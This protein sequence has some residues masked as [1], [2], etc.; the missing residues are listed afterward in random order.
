MNKESIASIITDKLTIKPDQAIELLKPG[1]YVAVICN[2]LEYPEITCRFEDVGFIIH[3]MIGYI[4]GV[5]CGMGTVMLAQKPHLKPMINNVEKY[6][7]GAMNID[8]CRVET[9]GKDKEKHLAEWNRNQSMS[10]QQGRN[11]MQGGLNAIDLNSFAKEGRHPA[12]LLHDGS[13]VVER[14]F[15][16]QSNAAGMHS[17]GKERNFFV[18]PTKHNGVQFLSDNKPRKHNRIGDS[19]SASRFFNKLSTKSDLVQWLKVLLTPPSE[20]CIVSVSE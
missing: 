20:E 1:G 11:S 19:G 17:A 8:G 13:E 5:N 10:A 16:E 18:N 12:N 14:E 9:Y 7:V 2:N 15:E 6:G 4:H 3:P